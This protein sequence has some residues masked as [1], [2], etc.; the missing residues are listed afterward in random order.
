MKLD[1]IALHNVIKAYGN[2]LKANRSEKKPPKPEISTKIDH[3]P[4]EKIADLRIAQYDQ[5]GL[6]KENSEKKQLLIDFF[7]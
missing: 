1:E 6:V 2:E 4:P 3:L 5:N 7:E